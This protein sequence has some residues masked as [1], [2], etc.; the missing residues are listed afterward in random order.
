MTVFT[1]ECGCAVYDYTV[2]TIEA[3]TLDEAL[4]NAV[5]AAGDAS[6]WTARDQCGPIFVDAVAEGRGANPWRDFRSAI[7]VP[8]DFTE[9]GALCAR[10]DPLPPAP[11]GGG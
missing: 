7:P 11:P 6:D 1:V 5:E 9:T 3:D 4:A 10:P 8:P 2:V